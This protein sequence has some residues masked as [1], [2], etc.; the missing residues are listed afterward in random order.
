LHMSDVGRLLAL[1]D[2]LV[3][4]GNTVVVIEH[5]LD[6]IAHAD[7]VIDLGPEGG[8]R[9]G[10]VLFEGTPTQ[11]LSARG[12]LTGEHLRLRG[13]RGSATAA[14]CTAP[15]LAYRDEGDEYDE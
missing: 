13:R 14:R 1:L 15:N 12:S 4:G 10:T 7:W 6:V 3:N 2:R 11:L 9:G 5:N 8:D